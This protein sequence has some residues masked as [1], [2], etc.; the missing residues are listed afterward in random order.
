MDNN[1]NIERKRSVAM[2]YAPALMRI[3]RIRDRAIISMF[4]HHGIRPSELS[5]LRVRDLEDHERISFITEKNRESCT[6]L[7]HPATRAA[8][9]EY[10]AVAAH[11][12]D[13]D[14]P[15]FQ[16]IR[17]G[18]TTRATSLSSAAILAIVRRYF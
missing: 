2:P 17:R 13:H 7:L 14:A 1:K 11:R 3:K 5:A 6:V 8:V 16:P 18:A 15:L 4:F 9:V 12:R 10:L